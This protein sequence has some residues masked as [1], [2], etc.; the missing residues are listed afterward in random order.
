MID[1][2]VV[3]SGPAGAVTAKILAENGWKVKLFE[4]R[5]L[6]RVKPCSGLIW[7]NAHK[8]L[9]KTV[10]KEIP[11]SLIA[12]PRIYDGVK[13]VSE[14]KEFTVRVK[15]I[16]IWR[17]SFDHWLAKEAER[18]GAEILDCSKLVEME[19]KGNFV[20]CKIRRS[21]GI[22]RVIAKYLIG[23]DGDSSVVR[24]QLNPGIELRKRILVQKYYKGSSD[25]P[26]N[27]LHFFLQK[28]LGSRA[29]TFHVK[30]GLC[31]VSIS[32]NSG[33][34]TKRSF[35]SFKEFLEKKYNFSGDL[36][37]GE[38]CIR[39]DL[40]SEKLR[41]CKGRIALVG[42][43][44]MIKNAFHEGISTAILSGYI[45]AKSV[46]EAEERGIDLEEVYSREI[47]DLVSRARESKRVGD[48][49]F[50]SLKDHGDI[51]VKDLLEDKISG[52][53]WS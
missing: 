14:E 27:F 25:L 12:E 17:N 49:L 23:A 51:N 50:K 22:E 18:A 21:G 52:L 38:A 42:D 41:I 7:P 37:T 48:F 10:G 47:E 15:L 24:L 13:L 1:A 11:E 34:R 4:W 9:K 43:A 19:D 36:V 39:N 33:A 26:E 44:A 30:D 46:I 53:L 40:K 6:P 16:N 45:A 32:E 5:K 31:I 2:V 20:E 8:A 29:G 35:E 28:D 3:G